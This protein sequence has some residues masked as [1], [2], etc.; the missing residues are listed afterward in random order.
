METVA[1]LAIAAPRRI[2]V[3]AVLATVGAGI[4]AVP[5]VKNLSGGGFQDPSSESAQAAALLAKKFHRTDSKMLI[6]LSS[7]DNVGSEPVRA[8]GAGIVAQL[9]SSPY[10]AHVVSPWDTPP[11][12]DASLISKDAKSALIVAD[13]V[14]GERDAP[15]YAKRLSDDLVHDRDGVT[16]RAGGSAAVDAQISERTEKDLLLMESIAVPLSFLVL[17]AVF[18]GLLAATLPLV[19]SG[20]AIIGSMAALHTIAVFTDV[21]T[22]G[23]NIAMALGL[24]LAIDYTL[25]ILSR[26]RDEVAGG[27][28]RDQALVYTMAAAGRTVLFSGAIVAS[29]TAPMLLFPTYF[30][31]SLAYA[32][33]AATAFA[34]LGA[35]VVTPALIA[36]LGERID[37]LDVRRLFRRRA[38]EPTPGEI[39]QTLGYRR[40]R[41]VMRHAIPTGLAG[42]ALLA[43]LGMPLL[44]VRSGVP[45]D[46]VLPTSAPAHHVGDALR[47]DF[48]TNSATTVDVVIPDTTGVTGEELGSYA[49]RLSLVPDVSWVSSPVGTF[50]G[51]QQTGPPTG[52]SAMGDDSAYLTVAS[53]A[54]LFSGMSRT[55]LDGL[56]AVRRP[57]GAHVQLAGAAQTDRD[58]GAAV[59][60]RLPIVLTLIAVSSILLLFLLT[61]SVMVPLKTL[62]LNVLSLTTTFGALVWIFQDGHLGAVGTTHTGALDLNMAVLLFCVAFGVSMDYQVFLI[63][64]VR[65]YWLTSEQTRADNDESVALGLARSGRVITAAA[66][67]MS[68]AFAGLIATH[69]SFM[70]MVGV[71]L[72][73]AILVDATLVRMILAPAFMHVLGRVNWWAPRPLARL[74]GGTGSSE[75]VSYGR[76]AAQAD[77]RARATPSPV[78]LTHAL[79]N[80]DLD[81]S[82][83]LAGRHHRQRPPGDP[84]DRRRRRVR[85]GAHHDGHSVLRS[86]QERLARRR[87]IGVRTG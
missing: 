13:I 52:I 11:Q 19:V 32:G 80:W 42:T 38:A 10:V 40:T 77:G 44:G 20:L 6:T 5:W 59:T 55:Q 7:Q 16:V 75:F 3:V 57:T 48:A 65:E 21:S 58:T 62:A 27:A 68:I 82:R 18:G 24:A 74:H 53:S 71:G 87:V 2:V 35:L 29:S 37:S 23:L 45:D 14:G 49:A 34:T 15:T 69:V 26:Y 70:R 46:R 64:R 12:V 28:S 1:R 73:L 78:R 39:E 47:T 22:F 4:F 84:A 50:V 33:I 54:P 17:V 36:L 9:K 31:K 72:T 51:G 81:Q 30:L 79:E 43:L 41:W 66:L 67:I 83:R 25:L 76:H 61:G 86:R 85:L 63:S 56:H 60:R 8:V